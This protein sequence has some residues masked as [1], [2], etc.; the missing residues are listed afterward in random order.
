MTKVT[1]PVL[2]HKGWLGIGPIY[3]DQDGSNIEARHPIF[4][5]LVN[6]SIWI[7]QLTNNALDTEY[8]F[9]IRVTGIRKCQ[10]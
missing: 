5:P 9:P 3:L 8:P 4:D 10:K 7:F 1:M 6:L 2:T